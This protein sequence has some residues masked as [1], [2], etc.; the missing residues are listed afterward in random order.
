MSAEQPA[1]RRTRAW[2]LVAVVV[3]LGLVGAV[4][5]R[6]VALL[7]GA[8]VTGAPTTIAP[9]MFDPPPTPSVTPA[10][11]N[12]LAAEA[13]QAP[14]GTAPDPATL[15]A[16]LDGLDTARLTASDQPV[17]SAFVVLD[18]AD[19]TSL[20]ATNAE[21][22]LIPASNTKLLTATAVM[23]AFDGSERFSTKVVQPD[24]TSI[25]LVGGG[26]PLLTT[27][28]V[29]ADTYPQPASLREL[30]QLTAEALQATGDQSVTLGYDATWFTGPGW[31]PSW[32]SKYRDQVT[33]ITALWADEGRDGNGARSQDPAAAAAASFAA[34]L[35]E[36]GITVTAPPQPVTGSGPELAAVES[37]PVH[38]LV[39]QAVLRSNN[40]FTEVLGFQLALATGH[41]ATFAGSAAAIREQLAGLGIWAEG[42]VL[43]DASGLSRANLVSAGLLADVMRYV[44][45]EPRL[46][47]V[48]DGLPVAG[49][50]GTLADRF[51]DEISQPARGIAR[52]KTGTLSG[53]ASLAGVSLTADG[54][55]VVFAFITN[56]SPDGWAAKVWSDQGA[57]IIT[58]CG[59]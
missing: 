43:H 36:L 18:A 29:A 45:S 50:T 58:G 57:G 42:A 48:L 4:A 17:T 39:E 32:P 23:N 46:S 47:G 11:G 2:V 14:A 13:P 26:D 1:P 41:P 8:I 34:Q 24:P 51:N 55:E 20:A 5:F 54:R 28:P 30:A 15:Q 53:V 59:C 10:I 21:V 40:S 35:T 56:G 52:A 19:G 12:G 33:P 38:V 49:V 44:V 31:N 3:A 22:S 25:V 7:T 9:E 6:P 27:E 16:R 37:L